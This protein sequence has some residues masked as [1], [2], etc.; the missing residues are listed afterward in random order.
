MRLSIMFV[1]RIKSALAAGDNWAEFIEIRRDRPHSN[2][3]KWRYTMTSSGKSS[4]DNV[5]TN[6]TSS[7]TCLNS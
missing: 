7:F 2:W 5:F 6:A 1:A 3:M 4:S